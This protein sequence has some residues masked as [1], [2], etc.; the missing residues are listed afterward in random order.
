MTQP[1]KPKRRVLRGWRALA[2]TIAVLA[3]CVWLD[4]RIKEGGPAGAGYCPAD[5]TWT[6]A[7]EDFSA[8]WRQAADTNAIARVREEWPR[9]LS[10][11]EL[12]VRKATGIRPTPSRW[13]LWMGRRFLMAGSPDG[14]GL[15]VYPGLL[16][17]AAH[18]VHRATLRA[19]RGDDGVFRFGE[20]SYGWREGYLIVSRSRPYVAASLAAPPAA[21]EE[22]LGDDELRVAWRGPSPAQFRMRAADGFPVSG[23]IRLEITERAAP[24]TLPDA[25]A[26]P[27]A[28]SITATDWADVHA[29]LAFIEEPFAGNPHWDE[30]KRLAAIVPRQWALDPLDAGW[31]ASADQCALALIGLEFSGTLPVPRAALV[32]RPARPADGP[33]P[34]APLLGPVDAIPYEWQ[35]YPGV[36]APLAGENLA[37]CLGRDERDWLA[38]TQEPVMAALVGSL[39]AG[40]AVPADVA[41]RLRWEPVGAAVEQAMVAMGEMELAGERNKA[42]VAADLLPVARG[43]ARLG[44][45]ELEGEAQDGWVEFEGFLARAA[46]E[47]EP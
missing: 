6:A 7:A 46:D 11:I 33:H 13:H 12:A 47:G 39:A 44:L 5:A 20:L 14:V 28:A 4:A 40:P 19:G 36:L 10:N 25:W 15:C 32:L 38:T 22:S 23:R 29:L 2:A 8:L 9:P 34:L 17:R 31:D 42:D 3:C 45:L 35:G 41:V 37:L 1:A 21:V 18:L 24:L 16:M 27:P 30:A 43:L 26:E